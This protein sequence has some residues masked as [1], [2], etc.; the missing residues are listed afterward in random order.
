MA[1]ARQNPKAHSPQPFQNFVDGKTTNLKIAT[2]KITNFHILCPCPAL[3]LS[4][5]VWGQTTLLGVWCLTTWNTFD[6]MFVLFP[7]T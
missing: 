5:R 1:G 7:F 6:F 2:P 4:T 3:T